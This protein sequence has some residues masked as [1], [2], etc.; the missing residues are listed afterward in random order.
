MLTAKAVD[1][2]VH[3]GYAGDMLTNAAIED[4]IEFTRL[5]LTH[6]ADPNRHLFEDMKTALAAVA[7]TASV[8]MAAL[9][10]D[11][12]A[13]LHGSG[14]I[15]LAAEAGKVEMV[16]FLLERGADVN[17]MGVWHPGDRRYDEDVGSALHRAIC[18][19]HDELVPFL[20]GEGAVVNVKDMKGRL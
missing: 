10:F 6:G 11:H 12:G 3:L 18:K 8:A 9:L 4:D 2:N 1:S 17:E 5:C 7:E 20:I 13:I 14:A 15:V 19:G 16:E